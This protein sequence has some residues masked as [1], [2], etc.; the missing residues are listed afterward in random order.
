MYSV[1]WKDDCECLIENA[2]LT[3]LNILFQLLRD[4]VGI[5]ITLRHFNKNYHPVGGALNKEHLQ[6]GMLDSQ[7]EIPIRQV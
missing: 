1:E 3:Y 4:G 7:L 5:K 6:A 2:D